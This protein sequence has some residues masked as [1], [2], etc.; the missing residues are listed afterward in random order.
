MQ[1]KQITY[2]KL[3]YTRNT[4]QY[5]DICHLNTAWGGVDLA[6]ENDRVVQYD[7][8]TDQCMDMLPLC[9][10]SPI[11]GLVGGRSRGVWEFG[12]EASCCILHA[13]GAHWDKDILLQHR[14]PWGPRRMD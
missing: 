7:K 8:Y 9:F 13:G 1:N 5:L 12:V 14:Q 11:V 4:V 10:M 6:D 3:N 2:L